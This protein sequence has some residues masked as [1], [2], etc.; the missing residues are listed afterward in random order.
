MRVPDAGVGH[1]LAGDVLLE[2]ALLYYKVAGAVSEEV[3]IT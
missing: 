3:N 1:D 2:L